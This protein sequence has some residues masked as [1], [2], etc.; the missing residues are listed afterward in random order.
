MVLVV[1][2]MDARQ[3]LRQNLEMRTVECGKLFLK[4]MDT[5]REKLDAVDDYSNHL[6]QS[7]KALAAKVEEADRNV[8]SFMEQASQLEA[9]RALLLSQS[10]EVTH[11]LSKYH[12]NQSEIQLLQQARL[13]V[14]NEARAFYATFTKLQQ[15]YKDCKVITEK[16]FY[17]IGF[18]LLDVLGKHQEAA[19]DKLFHWLRDKCEGMAEDLQAG[20]LLTSAQQ[21]NS[22]AQTAYLYSQLQTAARLLR[23][24]PSYFEQCQDLLITARR[25]Q[26]VQRFTQI[27]LQGYQN[28]STNTRLSAA[29]SAAVSSPTGGNAGEISLVDPQTAEPVG[30]LG[31]LLAWIHQSFALEKEF[32]ESIYY[33][34]ESRNNSSA[35]NGNSGGSLPQGFYSL[36]ELLVRT[37]QGLGRPL[38]MRILQ[39][40]ETH[41]S[42]LDTLYALA[43]LLVFYQETFWRLV[44]LE[45][46]VHSAL[47]GA[48]AECERIFLQQVR[49][50]AESVRL[51]T[52]QLS[53]SSSTSATN[54]SSANSSGA[55]GGAHHHHRVDLK[56][57]VVTRDCAQ[58][59]K[60]ILKAAS[61]ALSSLPFGGKNSSTEPVD[62]QEGENGDFGC[63]LMIDCASQ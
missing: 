50:H 41:A 32:F 38:R 42:S 25:S 57:S 28:T 4:E 56:A 53:L 55:N 62:Q 11:F 17:G 13:D 35:N 29:S 10:E 30:F 19:Y 49:R 2:T 40:L 12:L 61:M 21:N 22:H 39:L 54:G 16:Q 37:L 36:H 52:A 5:M 26:L 14:P 51:N 8:K 47:R 18:E 3:S 24:V 7:C 9:K 27:S 34:G 58:Q 45:N 43:D 44:P 6:Y 60:G 31:G 59:V 48:F 15:A 33:P 46:A 63:L 20:A 1:D 23:D